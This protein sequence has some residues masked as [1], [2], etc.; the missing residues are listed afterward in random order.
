MFQP[1]LGVSMSFV[2]K[3]LTIEAI[4]AIGSSRIETLEV[5]PQLFAGPQRAALVSAFKE[6][7][8]RSGIV[9]ATLHAA[10]EA[11]DD[12]SSLKESEYLAALKNMDSAIDQAVEFGAGVIVFHASDEPIEPPERR[13][14]MKQAQRALAEIEPKCRKAGKKTAIELLP[15]TCLGNTVEELFEILQPLSEETFGVCLD[16]NHLMDRYEDLAECVRQLGKR[17]IALHLSDYDG[18]DEKHEMPG[19]GVIDWKAFM[20]ALREI[21]YDGPLTY[22]YWLDADTPAERIRLLEENFRWLSSL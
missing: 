13:S 10:M 16:T 14:R 7:L 6:M 8:S 17:L 5:K 18:V 11:E 12:F 3:P 20:A 2:S 4:E 21:D 22:E 9:P 15:R 19:S 1:K